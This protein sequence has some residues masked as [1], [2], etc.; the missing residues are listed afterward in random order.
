V[1]RGFNLLVTT[2]SDIGRFDFNEAARTEPESSGQY[3]V[4]GDQ[5]IMQF[6]GPQPETIT[7]ALPRGRALK[8]DSVNYLRQ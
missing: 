3:A 4:Q 6:G 1:Y 8:I 2:S 5:L 7:A